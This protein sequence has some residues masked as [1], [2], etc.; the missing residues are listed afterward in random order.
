MSW[1]FKRKK[2]PP[3]PNGENGQPVPPMFLTHLHGVGIDMELTINLLEAYGIPHVS[4][5]P[6][7]GQFGK[8]IMGFPPGGMKIYV[9]ETMHEDALNILNAEISEDDPENEVETEI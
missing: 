6:L 8:L 3:W 7:N 5:Y 9:P 1:S 4:E 2:G